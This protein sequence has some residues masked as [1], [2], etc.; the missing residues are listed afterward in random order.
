MNNPYCFI[1]RDLKIGFKINLEIH[2]INYANSILTITPKFPDIGIETGYI[3]KNLKEMATLYARLINQHKFRYHILF[4]ASFYKINEEDQRSH[5]T[6]IFTNLNIN[7]NS[8]EF[9]T[10][11]IDLRTQ[12]E[13]QIQ[14]EEAKESGWIF[15]K[16]KSMKIRFYKTVELN[17]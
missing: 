9:G 15:D 1:K 5:E 14:M 17:G 8:T 11:I 7:I 2:N 6:E 3:N 12:S 16:I 10:D 4:S 13:H